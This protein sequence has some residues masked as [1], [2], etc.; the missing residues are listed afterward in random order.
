MEWW[1]QSGRY[2][3]LKGVE[4]DE[5]NP[6]IIPITDIIHHV[7]YIP[8]AR[9]SFLRIYPHLLPEEKERLAY[10][11]KE[12]QNPKPDPVFYDDFQRQKL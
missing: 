1:F 6:P 4:G 12:A 11:L 10:A 7:R 5:D 2:N 9:E 8:A 3:T